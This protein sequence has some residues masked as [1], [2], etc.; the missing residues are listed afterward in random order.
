MATKPK[1]AKG[2][3]TKKAKSAS[4]KRRSGRMKDLDAGKKSVKG[5]IVVNSLYT[6]YLGRTPR[7][8]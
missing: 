8:D 6:T 2:R 4:Q 1:A 5:G 3:T 7:D